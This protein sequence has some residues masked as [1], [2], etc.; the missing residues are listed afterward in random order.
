VGF[1][2]GAD[3]E[4]VANEINSDGG[5]AVAN[6][7][8]ATWDSAD[9]LVAEAIEAFGEVDI[10]INNATF[11]RFDDLWNHPEANW[12]ATFDVNLKDYFAM[13]RAVTPHMAERGS[14]VIVNTSSNSGM[15]HPTHGP[16]AAA[17]EGVVGLTRTVARELGRFG[18]R[19]NAIRPIAGGQSARD[20][21]A[22]T[23]KWTELLKS[24]FPPR[25]YTVQQ[26]MLH[27]VDL[28]PPRKISPLV[29][30]LCSDAAGEVNGCT[31]ETHGDTVSLLSEPAPLRSMHREGGWDLDALDALAPSYLVPGVTN[32]FRLDDHPEL[33]EFVPMK[34]RARRRRF[35]RC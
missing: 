7:T 20:Y 4:A 33:K 34:L 18:I 16:Y 24:T 9:R 30:W 21:E 31:F 32:D 17:K 14:G 28:Y 23:A 35:V 13:I 8:S 11:T 27:D 22:R 19:R 12:D 1:R 6:M 25:I 15:G 26:R 29:A 10:L 3:A 5:V 2:A